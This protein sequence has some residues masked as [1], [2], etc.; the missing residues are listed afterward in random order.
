MRL[1]TEHSLKFLTRPQLLRAI[2]AILALAV[3]V[4]GA[5][6]D[7]RSVAEN[8]TVLYDAPSTRASKLFVASR[9]TPV[10]I[11]VSIEGWVKVRDH[12]GDLTWVEKKALSDLRT[13]VVTATVA[14]ARLSPDERSGLVFQAS[15][16]VALELVE[17]ASG[18]WV[19]VRHRDGPTGFMRMSQ[20]WGL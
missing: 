6:A 5:S 10:E 20:L 16:G 8:G 14:D 9:Y 4:P 1:H 7:F 19:K 11:V 15:K 17:L 2:I 18:A 12:A 3:A 13:V